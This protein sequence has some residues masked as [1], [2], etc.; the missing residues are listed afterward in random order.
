MFK[1]DIKNYLVCIIVINTN[2]K[3]YI[4][5]MDSNTAESSS[6]S[7][8]KLK[9]DFEAEISRY[10]AYGFGMFKPSWMQRYMNNGITFAFICS[11]LNFLTGAI[12][13]GALRVILLFLF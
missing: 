13:N 1:M 4:F 5:R 9:A 8:T 12:T 3:K 2:F 7:Q 6:K 10:N 11:S